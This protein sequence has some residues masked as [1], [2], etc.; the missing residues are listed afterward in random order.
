MYIPQSLDVLRLILSNFL[1]DLCY[2]LCLV[3]NFGLSERGREVK[4]GS[5]LSLSLFS[6]NNDII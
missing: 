4:G 6:G 3:I 2:A 5:L 1:L